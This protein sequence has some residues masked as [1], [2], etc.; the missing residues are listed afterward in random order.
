V[1][2]VYLEGSEVVFSPSKG[3]AAW[4]PYYA[5]V[6]GTLY[7]S[8]TRTNRVARRD[9]GL[10]RGVVHKLETWFTVHLSSDVLGLLGQELQDP[11]YVSSVRPYPFQ[12]RG[13][14]FLRSRVSAMLLD[15]MGLG[16][17]M[18]AL[19][20]APL[21]SP[22]L[23]VCPKVARGVWAA[24]AR[25][26]RSDI[27]EI[28]TIKAKGTFRWPGPRELVICTYEMLPESWRIQVPP[29][30]V[31]LIIDEGHNVRTSGTDRHKRV[32]AIREEVT[33]RK[34]RAYLLTAT[35]LENR[36]PD[37][38][39]LAVLMGLEREAFGSRA[40]F[41]TMFAYEGARQ[42]GTP[43]P[44]AAQ[45]LRQIAIRRVK[46]DVQSEIPAKVIQTVPV[47]VTLSRGDTTVI[48]EAEK[49]L[50]D[51]G[52]HLGF[53]Q[54]MAARALLA[55]AKIPALHELLDDLE[56][57]GEPIVVFS[58]HL[59]P[60]ESLSR[61]PG[62]GIITGATND[63]QRIQDLFQAGKLL[64]IGGTIGAMGTALTLTAAQHVVFVDREWNPSRNNQAED[65]AVRIGQKNVVT[66]HRMVAE[67][68]LDQLVEEII[69][70]KTVSIEGSI[71][72][73]IDEE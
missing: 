70:S 22:I 42:W 64:G 71:D 39:N 73:M 34:G 27:K 59:A 56:A 54:I 31:V 47:E 41:R 58:C 72:R 3:F 29:N 15:D 6:S 1:I 2:D 16:K 19:L 4:E 26:F 38:W 55:K 61:R 53:D 50:L 68:S 52:R 66:I 14:E 51:A 35:P 9:L 21:G 25:K 43:L 13:I 45:A 8:A 40:N 5:A 11:I 23:V 17:T 63:R 32:A 46:A 36:P 48:D 57:V 60:I 62:W 33:S 24:E 65:R 7:D 69:S 44:E 28:H 49:W 30:G 18:Q 37:L 12:E 67:N 10:V 20:A